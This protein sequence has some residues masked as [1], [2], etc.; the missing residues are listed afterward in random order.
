M[1]KVHIYNISAAI[2]ITLCRH[3]FRGG[4]TL[5][6][7]VEIIGVELN[8]RTERFILNLRGMVVD[9]YTVGIYLFIYF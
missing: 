8:H 9:N 2:I 3:S 6:T 4:N 5:G 1:Y 7:L